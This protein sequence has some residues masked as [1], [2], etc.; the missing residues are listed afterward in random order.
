[1]FRF[2]DVSLG[3]VDAERREAR[4]DL[5]DAIESA[6]GAA[7]DV[8]KPEAALIAPGENL[9]QGRQGLSAGDVRG[10][11]QQHLDLDVVA[12][13]RIPRHPTARLEVKVL[14]IVAGPLAERL[15]GADLPMLAAFAPAMNRGQIR[16]EEAR[17]VQQRHQ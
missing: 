15:L 13:R 12:P 5:L 7:A 17:P 4:P 9:M 16:E 8:E 14:K 3:H 11:M 1:M 6:P 10:S 2:R